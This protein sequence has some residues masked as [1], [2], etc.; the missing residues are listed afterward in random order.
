[1]DNAA[2]PPEDEALLADS[3]GRTLLAVLEALPPAEAL[4]FVL[5]DMFALPA[6][7]IA[8]ITNRSTTSTRALAAAARH[9]IHNV[10]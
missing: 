8:A 10:P 4:A 9:R 1:M 7:E 6:E 5:H 2:L 3:A